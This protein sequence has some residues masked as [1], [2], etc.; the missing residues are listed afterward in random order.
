MPEDEHEMS[1]EGHRYIQNVSFSST[2]Y[3]TKQKEIKTL[4]MTFLLQENKKKRHIAGRQPYC[5]RT[6][7]ITLVVVFSFFFLLAFLAT[8]SAYAT[9]YKKTIYIES[10]RRCCLDGFRT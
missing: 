7:M 6:P 10:D 3:C 5:K 2:S 9:I 1:K 4:V 8:M